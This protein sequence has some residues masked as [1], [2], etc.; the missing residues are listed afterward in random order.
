M[1]HLFNV[2]NNNPE[3]LDQSPLPPNVFSSND[4]TQKFTDEKRMYWFQVVD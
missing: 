2:I 4:Q 1:T 3:L